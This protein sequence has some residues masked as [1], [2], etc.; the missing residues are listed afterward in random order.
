M[1]NIFTIKRRGG[2]IVLAS[3][4]LM[5]S[6]ADDS[7]KKMIVCWGDSLTAP[8]NSKGVKQFVKDMVGSLHEFDGSYPAQMKDMLPEDFEIVNC[9]VGGENT[10]AIMG[11]QGAAPLFLAHDVTVHKENMVVIGNRDITA[12][13]SS[14]DSTSTVHI[15]NQSYWKEG[16]S[17][18]NP[19]LINGKEVELDSNDSYFYKDGEK[20]Y[21]EFTY[22]LTMKGDRSELTHDT[23][24]AL[25]PITTQAMRDY[26]KAWCN[27]FF[28]GQNGGYHNA[29]ELI[30]QFKAMIRYSQCKR[31]VIVSH[32]VPN[33]VEPTP[34]RMAEVEDSLQHA[35]GNRYIN[36]RKE[37]ISKGLQLAGL[38]ATQEDRDS[39]AHN[40]VPPQLLEDKCH[41]TKKGYNVLAQL[42][43]QRIK[44]LYINK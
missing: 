25:S 32:H 3:L 1:R 17:H 2:V 20:Y 26:R 13:V 11:R 39:I 37:I 21:S 19:A 41:F 15:L 30:A 23:L 35:F 44:K 40:Q 34:Q 9:G 14:W 28:M 4:I 8:H 24:R 33:G 38:T 22:R 36:L 29:A 43:S 18:V 5:S 42:V 12:F 6:C 31:C 10:L 7:E 27:V 16:G